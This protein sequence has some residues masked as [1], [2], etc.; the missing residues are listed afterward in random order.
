MQLITKMQQLGAALAMAALCSTSVFATPQSD[1]TDALSDCADTHTHWERSGQASIGA[2]DPKLI[3]AV[4]PTS[5]LDNTRG[6]AAGM[7]GQA[8]LGGVVSGNSASNIVTGSNSIDTGSFANMSGI[9][10]VIQNTGANVL[11]QSAT[12]VNVS[13]K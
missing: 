10:V 6:K 4:A 5:K 11:I 9:P 3:G 12:I 13:F 7:T 8:D 1:P 2:P